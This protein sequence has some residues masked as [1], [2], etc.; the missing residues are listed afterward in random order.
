[1]GKLYEMAAGATANDDGILDIDFFTD[2]FKKKTQYSDY[3]DPKPEQPA[4]DDIPASLIDPEGDAKTDEYQHEDVWSP[5]DDD[6]QPVN[7]ERFAKTGRHIAKLFDTG[8]DLTMSNLVAKGSGNSY[9]AS[10]KDIDDLGEAW[11]ELAEDKQWELGP[12]LRVAIMTIAIYIPLARRAFEDRRIMELER[13]ADE[14]EQKQHAQ[15]A[16]IKELENE[17]YRRSNENRAGNTA[18]VGAEG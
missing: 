16:R 15:E 13:R 2:Q 1:M 17:L 14:T 9:H 4:A 12:G 8:F 10:E 7:P 18:S 6:R 3:Y 11:G 5:D